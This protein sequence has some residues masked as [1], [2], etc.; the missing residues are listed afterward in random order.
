M[1]CKGTTVRMF[2]SLH[3]IR[4]ERGLASRV[5]VEIP[6]GGCTARELAASLD[7]PMDKVEAVF[8][9]HR[10][11]PLQR[12]VE[13]GDRVAFIPTGIPAP[14][15]LMLGIHRAGQQSRQ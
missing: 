10:V 5:E 14:E 9:N 2:G 7:L 1:A 13:P 6:A 4:R 8:I 12:I 15:R 3:T 11:H